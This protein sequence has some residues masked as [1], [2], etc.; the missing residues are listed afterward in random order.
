MSKISQFPWDDFYII[1]N[2]EDRIIQ[3]L[4]RSKWDSRQY[5]H[6]QLKFEHTHPRSEFGPSKIQ[7]F[8]GGNIDYTFLR[9]FNISVKYENKIFYPREQVFDLE[10]TGEIEEYETWSGG[11]E[12]K[13]VM[14]KLDTFTLAERPIQIYE[15]KQ[16]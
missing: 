5:I 3:F 6:P 4:G 13:P 10:E 16:F 15:I 1:L 7:F 12:K 2:N 9:E 8:N 14:R 11:Y